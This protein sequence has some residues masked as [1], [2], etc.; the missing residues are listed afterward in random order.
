M[1]KR[2]FC[3]RLP[4]KKKTTLF[5]AFEA[6]GTYNV[7]GMFLVHEIKAKSLFGKV[8]NGTMTKRGNL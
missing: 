8:R 1:V 2:L 4:P 6:K 5:V 3:P 7:N